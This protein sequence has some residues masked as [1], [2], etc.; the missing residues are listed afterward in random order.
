MIEREAASAPASIRPLPDLDNGGIA[1]VR[2]QY[3]EG[4]ALRAMQDHIAERPDHPDRILVDQSLR[5]VRGEPFGQ[6]YELW[7]DGPDRWRMNT[8]FWQMGEE[9][10]WDAAMHAGREWWF[11]RDDLSLFEP[12]KAPNAYSDIRAFRSTA[13][14]DLSLLLTG[15]LTIVS[16]LKMRI[17]NLRWID[18]RRF[19]FRA[20]RGDAPEA[21]PYTLDFTGH[22]RDDASRF[23]IDTIELVERGASAS[24][25]QKQ[26]FS[27]WALVPEINRWAAGSVVQTEPGS[28]VV[29]LVSFEGGRSGTAEELDRITRVPRVDG[30]DPRRGPVTVRTVTDHRSG[31]AEVIDP[32]GAIPTL[33]LGDRG[34][35]QGLRWLGVAVLFA[36][37]TG[38]GFILWKR[39]S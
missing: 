32:I 25:G 11:T 15:R 7:T 35:G 39:R 24:V 36:G 37:V 26:V 31:R 28:E 2:A 14:E 6:R 34:G 16:D 17:E 5:R 4:P 38:L 22:W 12:G 18:G 8:M 21:P 13:D 19:A 1:W 20:V 23:F 3:V 10:Y 9:Y 29:H 27:G 33:R 30:E